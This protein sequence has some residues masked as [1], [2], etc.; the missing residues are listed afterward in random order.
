MALISGHFVGQ[1]A[2]RHY[3]VSLCDKNWRWPSVPWS[4]GVSRRIFESGDKTMIG[5][6][7]SYLRLIWATSGPGT[8]SQS[9]NYCVQLFHFILYVLG[10]WPL[11]STRGQYIW[12]RL[13]LEIQTCRVI[14]VSGFLQSWVIFHGTILSHGH[15]RLCPA[16][17]LLV[18]SRLWHQWYFT[19]TSMLVIW[20]CVV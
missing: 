4:G 1:Q 14:S 18:L 16:T 3:S 9:C 8:W 5:I 2:Q 19:A 6:C 15:C 7:S 11:L 10:F 20:R 13:N 17:R 12:R